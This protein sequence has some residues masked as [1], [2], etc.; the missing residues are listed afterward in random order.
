MRLRT[1]ATD[2]GSSTLQRL[3]SGWT[4]RSVRGAASESRHV[5]VHGSGVLR[6]GRPRVLEF[7]FGAGT[8]FAT[9]CAELPGPERRDLTYHAIERNPVPAEMLP[10]F[11]P[12]SA[13]L[14]RTATRTGRAEAA[15]VRL[16]IHRCEFVEFEPDGAYDAVFFDPFGPSEEPDSWS[17]AVFERAARALRRGGRLVTYSAAGWVR[18]NMATAGLFVATVPGLA[19]GKREFTIAAA[20]ED[21]LGG[22]KV[23]NAPG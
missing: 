6:T 16:V 21:A 20:T 4:Y 7:G 22:A 19:G 5:F 14:A 15:G 3:D 10:E 17:S 23:R 8:N 12:S 1:I 18:R 13:A 9:L 11:D 2:D